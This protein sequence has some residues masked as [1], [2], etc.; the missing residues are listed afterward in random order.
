MAPPILDVFESLPAST[1]DREA[2]RILDT[3][4]I[5]SD[6]PNRTAPNLYYRRVQDWAVTAIYK[7]DP[8]ILQKFLDPTVQYIEFTRR[9][10]AE[11]ILI[12]ERESFVTVKRLGQHVLV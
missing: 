2:A 10:A 3:R 5:I 12:I 11:G 8:A 9:W 4:E 1:R 6:H 7:H